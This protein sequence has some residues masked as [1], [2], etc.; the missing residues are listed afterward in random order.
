LLFDAD[1][2]QGPDSIG[3]IVSIGANPATM[4]TGVFSD[5]YGFS[6]NIPLLKNSPYRTGRNRQ[7]LWPV[8]PLNRMA[9][10]IRRPTENLETDRLKKVTDFKPRG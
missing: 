6:V 10:P 3:G 7:R 4:R 9:A 5:H 8:P 1:K 2:G